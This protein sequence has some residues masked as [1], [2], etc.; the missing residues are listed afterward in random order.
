MRGQQIDTNIFVVISPFEIQ[1]QSFE[2]LTE[3]QKFFKNFFAK[4]NKDN[5]QLFLICFKNFKK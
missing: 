2:F 1:S 3:P 5:K 4:I